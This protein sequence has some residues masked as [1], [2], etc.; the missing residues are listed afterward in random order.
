[1]WG[2][3]D[4]ENA[5]ALV[6]CHLVGD[7]V[8]QG[9]FIAKTKGENWYH[10]FVHSALYLLPFYFLLGFTPMLALIFVT[11]FIVDAM[12]AR[13]GKIGYVTD[14]MFHYVVLLMVWAAAGG[15]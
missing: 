14:Q 9:E 13:Y 1:M 8:L 10:L 4:M 12:K 2:W 5:F 7:Y 6:L 3:C 11:H 15:I